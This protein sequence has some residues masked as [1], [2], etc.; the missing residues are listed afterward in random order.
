M[1]KTLSRPV[2]SNNYY[3]SPH[4]TIDPKT[5]VKVFLHD[6]NLLRRQEK[7][8]RVMHNGKRCYL[9]C[10]D[11]VHARMDADYEQKLAAR[12]TPIR[13]R[14]YTFEERASHLKGKSYEEIQGFVYRQHKGFKI[15]NTNRFRERSLESQVKR[16]K[17]VWQGSY[18]TQKSPKKPK[19][20]KSAKEVTEEEQQSREGEGRT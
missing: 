8:S 9:K 3:T 10:F 11:E 17:R 19:V 1:Y 7:G 15:F 20:M 18:A 6:T 4:P 5:K 2:K 14:K 13:T 16:L 12:M